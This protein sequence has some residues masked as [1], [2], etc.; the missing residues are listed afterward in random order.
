[1]EADTIAGF[2]QGVE[3]RRVFGANCLEIQ[4]T[5]HDL[6]VVLYAMM[7]PPSKAPFSPRGKPGISSTL[8]YVCDIAGNANKAPVILPVLS[9]N[10]HLGR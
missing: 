10:G 8:V 1:M 3:R 4:E 9:R 2:L 6:Q 5:D 7:N